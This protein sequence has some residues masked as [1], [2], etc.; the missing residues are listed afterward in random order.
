M[1]LTNKF[2]FLQILLGGASFLLL[3][4]SCSK[5]NDLIAQYVVE[6]AHQEL[7]SYATVSDEFSVLFGSEN[8]LDVLEND[9]FEADQAVKIINVSNPSYGTVTINENS[10]LEYLAPDSTVIVKDSLVYTVEIIS[11]NGVKALETGNVNI[12]VNNDSTPNN[13]N[14]HNYL[15]TVQAKNILKNRFE[16]GYVAG[17]GFPDD[18]TKTIN[19]SII[20]AENP[21][22][23]RPI[24]GSNPYVPADGQ[25][26]HTTAIYAYAVDDIKLANI[27]AKEILE[28]VESND[29]YTP[30]WNNSKSYRWDTDNQ[31]W[32]QTAKVKK[33]KDS[34]FFIEK[35]QTLLTNDDKYLIKS[36][37]NRYAN[38]A[39][40]AIKPRLEMYLG[41]N[42]ETLGESKFLPEGIYPGGIENPIQDYY[43]NDLDNYTMAW[44]QDI[45]NNRQWDAI[46]YIHS[47]AIINNDIEKEIWS[48]QFFKS[49]LKFGVFPDGTLAEMWRNTESDV[50]KGVFYGWLTTGGA[51][52]MAHVDAMANHFPNDRLYD[53]QTTDG[54]YNESTNLTKSGYAGA[55]TTDGQTNKNLLLVLKGQSNYLR[56]KNNGGW[57]D[58]RFYRKSDNSIEPLS[59][60]GVRQP[61]S[62]PAMA[63]LYYKSQDLKDF[64]LYNTSVGY[65]EKINISEGYLAI[66]SGSEDMG[67]WGTLIMGSAWFEQEVNFFN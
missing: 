66:I 12:L 6:D 7:A 60:I 28:I 43:G 45:Y 61:S 49:F 18:I 46:N 9:H 67:P 15:Y 11:V 31:L 42:W 62:I 64:Y 47:I 4:S 33:I 22:E 34:Y 53:Y 57:N 17:T 21:S 27:V 1:N 26:L 63:N 8:T 20:F 41:F 5:D 10:T 65:P 56:N 50:T 59:T 38:L 54:I 36:W 29:L 2:Y 37:L 19:N 3:L 14:N 40:N 39:Y 25:T 44:A 35:V 52:Q 51:V 30:Y 13:I 24:I 58:Q 48:R 55:S 16:L 32:I 23:F